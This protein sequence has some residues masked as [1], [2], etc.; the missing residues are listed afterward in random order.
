[1]GGGLVTLGQGDLMAA[2]GE[3]QG[4]GAADALPRPR[5]DASARAHMRSNPV[6]RPG[7]IRHAPMRASIAARPCV[8]MTPRMMMTMRDAIISVVRSFCP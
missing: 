5:D 8:K 6:Q 4:D 3:M 1:M 7:P 2:A